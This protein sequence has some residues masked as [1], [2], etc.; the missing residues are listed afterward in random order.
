MYNIYNMEEVNKKYQNFIKFLQ[1]NIKNSTYVSLL[2]T[3][4]LER[5]LMTLNNETGTPKEITDKVCLK[6]NIDL[7]EYPA[8]IVLKFERYITYFQKICKTL[9]K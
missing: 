3:A 9:Y 8:D 1:D 4:S 6:F 2:A 5:F 7:S